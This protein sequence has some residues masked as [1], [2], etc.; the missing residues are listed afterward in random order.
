MPIPLPRPKTKAA[1]PS[2]LRSYDPL[3]REAYSSLRAKKAAI[4]VDPRVAAI[5][6]P[7]SDNAARLL[8]LIVQAHE[9][10]TGALNMG[11]DANTAAISEA[12][13]IPPDAATA[14]RDELLGRMLLAETVSCV[15]GPGGH[16]PVNL[17]KIPE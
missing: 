13:D 14:A 3:T 10:Q 15:G 4:N 17:P 5:S 11:V 12:L 1:K 16:R 7:L 6:P 9:A 8:D 2:P